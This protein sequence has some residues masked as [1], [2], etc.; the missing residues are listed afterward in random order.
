MF[1]MGLLDPPDGKPPNRLFE[2][3]VAHE[4]AKSAFLT[5]LLSTLTGE[6]QA[7][8]K[9][10][11]AA[12]YY[13][14]IGKVLVADSLEA[15][16]KRARP[17]KLGRPSTVWGWSE[18]YRLMEDFMELVQSTRIKSISRI[19]ELLSKREPWKSKRDE[20]GKGL[21][22]NALRQQII[23]ITKDMNINIKILMNALLRIEAGS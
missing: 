9:V 11:A 15:A 6:E 10:M 13:R 16:L 7:E 14:F 8:A 4:N 22:G 3:V 12:A 20:N 21:M 1:S 2:L 5:G 23:K 17:R 19:C 18:R